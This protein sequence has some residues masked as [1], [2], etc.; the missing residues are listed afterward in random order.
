MQWLFLAVPVVV[1]FTFILV[2]AVRF[3]PSQSLQNSEDEFADFKVESAGRHLSQMIQK[4]TVSSRNEDEIDHSAFD[5]FTALLPELYP[6]AHRVLT[7]E[8]VN[9]HALLY[10][11]EGRTKEKPVVLMAHYDVVSAD[12]SGWKHPPFAGQIEDGIIWGRGALDTKVTLASILEAAESLI[13]EGF[14]PARDIYM[15]FSNNEETAGDSTPAI[16][17]LFEKR[18]IDPFFVLDEGGAVVTKVFSGVTTPVAL[19]GVAEKGITDVEIVVKSAGG[20][21]SSPPKD[22]AT[23]QLSRIIV[24]LSKHPFRARFPQ[25]T[26]EML[27][28][29][30][31]HTPFIYRIIFANLWL[32]KPLLL[33]VFANAGG[34]MNAIVRTTVAVTKLE[35]S[36]GANVLASQAKATANVRIAVGEN[37]ES[38]VNRILRITRKTGAQVTAIYSMEPSPVSKTTG[39][40]YELLSSVIHKT[41]PETIISPYVMLG[42]SDSRHFARISSFV[43]RFSPME[44]TKAERESMHA[45]NEAIPVKKLDTCISFYIRLIRSI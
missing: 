43:Y 14:T 12:E 7:K 24:S 31:R 15:S 16:V 30:G 26:I 28:I 3:T 6:E 2:R 44:L 32:F 18:G 37:A 36:R 1:L 35:G 9:Q 20:H 23:V 25:P 11:W 39:A 42:G 4:Q 17:T 38:V 13:K 33:V 29:L 45:A 41:F 27:K 8:L 34:E 10:R 40:A 5:A 19:V 22:T 21:A